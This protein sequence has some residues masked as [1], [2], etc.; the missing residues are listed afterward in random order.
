[1]TLRRDNVVT[2]LALLVI[3]T[4]VPFAIRDTIE[5]GRVY[6]FSR[7][8]LEELPQRFTGPGPVSYTHLTLP[9]ILLV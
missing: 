5:M 8:F 9:T 6:L 7:P 2:V 3:V 4:T 1:M